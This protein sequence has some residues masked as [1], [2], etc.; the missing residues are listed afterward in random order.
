MSVCGTVELNRCCVEGRL[1]VHTPEECS[2]PLRVV[3]AEVKC[4]PLGKWH[5]RPTVRVTVTMTVT[6]LLDWRMEH[7]GSIANYRQPALCCQ[8]LR[9][10]DEVES[11]CVCECVCFS[12]A[13]RCALDRVGL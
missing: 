1:G 10:T 3:R 8:P 6:V 7:G 11:V 5:H 2:L 9:C 12:C 4:G 13:G